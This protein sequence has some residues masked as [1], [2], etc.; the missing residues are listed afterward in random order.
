MHKL[1]KNYVDTGMGLE[2]I[3]SLVQ[4]VP[5]NYA[6]DLFTPYFDTMSKMCNWPEYT[7]KLDDPKD[8]AY[9]IIADHIRM[10][11]V[12]IADQVRP[13]DRGAGYLL[14]RIIR[15]AIES[16]RAVSSQ[17]PLPPNV[18]ES[19]LLRSLVTTSVESLGEA[20]PELQQEV[21]QIYKVIDDEVEL[22]STAIIRNVPI[23]KW[24]ATLNLKL[25]ENVQINSAEIKRKI[26]QI[27][28]NIKLAEQH[29][30]SKKH[31]D[32]N[33]LDLC[34]KD[35]QGLNELMQNDPILSVRFGLT[36]DEIKTQL[37]NAD[38]QLIAVENEYNQSMKDLIVS[39]E[40][41]A[42]KNIL[43]KE[44]SSVV[45]INSN[46]TEYQ[47]VENLL[48]KFALD[49]HGQSPLATIIVLSQG[50]QYDQQS[51]PHQQPFKSCTTLLVQFSVPGDNFTKLSA[52]LWFKETSSQ[53][54]EEFEQLRLEIELIKTK[55]PKK[56]AKYK[57]RIYDM[58]N[59]D[60]FV[61]TFKQ[62]SSDVAQC[63][64]K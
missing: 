51:T 63:F 27:K 10:A 32:Y 4:G 18:T 29:L 21:D 16:I 54:M 35:L 53:T 14:R 6:T 59:S 13:D 31:I 55:R 47:D 1:N 26:E 30:A 46:F 58:E 33:E 7:H 50:E 39:F 3:L 49:L 44:G 19:K 41:E 20:F 61:Q 52:D 12:A 37:E 38:S 28:E 15:R 2:R 60:E 42:N 45:V 17:K 57:L 24:A 8:V 64:Y 62:C 25:S 11:S 43:T 23:M 40:N 56:L 48:L 9:R 5:N 36:T 34:R 22:Y